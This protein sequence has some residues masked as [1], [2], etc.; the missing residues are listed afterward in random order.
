MNAL[1]ATCA[2]LCFALLPL[3]VLV[4]VKFYLH[5]SVAEVLASPEWSFGSAILSGQ[6]LVRIVSG[7][8]QGLRHNTP[9]LALVVATFFVFAIVPALVV[10]ALVIV[11][12]AHVP[13]W[14]VILQV[15]MFATSATAFV[16]LG[17]LGH[18]WAE[19]SADSQNGDKYSR[20]FR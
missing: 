17:S 20:T 5:N 7:L 13:R 15:C 19:R 6:A 10:L 8:S 9:R 3:L 14:L 18:L 4:L 12:E 16:L 2:E 1:A 11:A